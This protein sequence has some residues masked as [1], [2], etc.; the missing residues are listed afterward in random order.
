VF[1]WH[2]T[3][4]WFILIFNAVILPGLRNRVTTSINF[5]FFK[6]A[7]RVVC[8]TKW[9]AHT[10]P[11]FEVL[12]VLKLQDITK[13]QAG[14]F[15]YKAMS[16]QL[17]PL[18]VDYFTLNRDLHNHYTRQSQ[19][20]HIFGLK[21]TV[22]KYSIKYFG[23]CLWNSLPMYITTKPSIFSFKKAYKNFLLSA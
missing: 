16:N 23:S 1:F 15:M 20:I 11:L 18:F 14:C 6:K 10:S 4:L 7:L 21:T 19:N 13:L 2:Y 22:R 12:K 8:K 9:D 3:T 5:V 17:P